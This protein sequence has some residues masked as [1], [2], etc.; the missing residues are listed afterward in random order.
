MTDFLTGDRSLTGEPLVYDGLCKTYNQTSTHS[1]PSE[2]CKDQA[3][4]TRSDSPENIAH[5]LLSLD[6][7]IEQSDPSGFSITTDNNIHRSHDCKRSIAE[8]YKKPNHSYIALI[9]MAILSTSQK[10]MLLSDIYQYITDNFPY[11]RNKDKSWRNSIRHNLSLNECFTKNG[12]SENGK[13]NFWSIHPAC[14]EDFSKG[15]FRRRRA[16]R[17][18]RKCH[19]D[20][21]RVTMTTYGY[22]YMSMNSPDPYYNVTSPYNAF[23]PMSYPAASALPRG[24]FSVDGFYCED[25]QSMYSRFH[26]TVA[27]SPP[28]VAATHFNAQ[29]DLQN[30]SKTPLP[31]WQDTLSRLPSI[32]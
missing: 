8:R 12:R 22:G 6:S 15:D 21:E 13:G 9:S 4:L 16:R 14:Q 2:L 23:V 32:N 17:R 11:Y 27:T 30:S 3:E 5:V 25:Q 18:V 7:G 24:L 29:F 1:Y 28:V 26:Q 31:S 20:Q 10:K 19:R